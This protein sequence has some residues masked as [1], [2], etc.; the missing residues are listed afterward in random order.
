M[1]DEPITVSRIRR[2]IRAKEF[3]HARETELHDGI[4]EVLEGLG[5]PVRREVTLDEKNRID[6]TTDLPRTEGRPLVLGIEVKIAGK[7]GDVRR[8][9]QRYS[10]FAQLG[11]LLLVT[12]IRRHMAEVMACATSA[13]LDTAAGSRWRI[14]DKPFDLVLINRG[15]L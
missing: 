3:R 15:L 14:G 11:A 10:Q 7:P 4:Q 13:P 9:V 12:T 8:Q 5:L 1:D 6:L 2:E